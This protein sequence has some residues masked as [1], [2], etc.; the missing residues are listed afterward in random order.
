MKHLCRGKVQRGLFFGGLERCNKSWGQVVLS[1]HPT[2]NRR[3]KQ[4]KAS[5]ALYFALFGKKRSLFCLI[6]GL[7]Y[8]LG[9]TYQV[10]PEP[11]KPLPELLIVTKVAFQ[12]QSL[13]LEP[14]SSGR[15]SPLL[16]DK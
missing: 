11:E 14:P 1:Q 3:N 15:E 2:S 12:G 7:L 8:L 4:I 9:F 16:I 6:I 13:L 5:K 10:S